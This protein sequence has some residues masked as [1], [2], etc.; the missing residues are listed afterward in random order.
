MADP[1]PL[2]PRRRR[3]PA[4][5]CQE[6]RSRKIRCDQKMPCAACVRS[7]APL[8]CSYWADPSGVGAIAPRSASSNATDLLSGSVTM[9]T[10]ESSAGSLPGLGVEPLPSRSHDVDPGVLQTSQSS[11]TMNQQERTIRELRR[12]V[13]QLEHQLASAKQPT[14]TPSGITSAPGNLPSPSDQPLIEASRSSETCIL[15]TRPKLRNT[16][17]KTKLFGPSHWVHTAEKV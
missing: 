10:P 7:R 5:S 9:F 2:I 6:C 15:P 17:H 1:Q 3:R 16:S 13:H 14:P 11:T 8:Q 12:Q 4:K